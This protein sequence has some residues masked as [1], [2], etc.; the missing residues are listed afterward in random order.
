MNII[1]LTEETR[2]S[3][4]CAATIGFF[5]GVHK[6][7]RHLI[8]RMNAVAAAKRMETTV[9]TFDRH[10]REV[11]GGD[12]H[13]QLLS[14]Y[15][16]KMLLL[17]Q[18]GIDNC[19]IIPFNDTVAQ[20][21]AHDFMLHL[22]K[23]RLSVDTLIIGHDHRFGH[24]RSEDFADYVA[25]GR[26]MGIDVLRGEALV[27]EGVAV[28]S[29]VVRS[30]LLEGETAM[31]EKCLGYQY[32]FKGRVVKGSQTGTAMGFPTANTEP[33][34]PQKLIPAAGVYGVRVR[35]EN[36][37]QNVHAMTNI[38][39]RPTFDG[40]R[41]TI[42]THIFRFSGDLYGQT[43]TIYFGQ[44]LRAERKFPSQ[45]ELTAQLSEDMIAI[46]EM[47]IKESDTPEFL[48]VKTL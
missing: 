32:S 17:A 23:E 29:S 39:T 38:G 34:S 45:E 30:L 33:L 8:E 24:G 44:R 20:T 22:L 14:T 10:P 31:A 42:E 48:G 7:H 12:Y 46:D 47:F 15:D 26:E 40:Q 9:I 21:S 11:L 35:L 25:Y 1:R 16:E 41:Q 4:P 37:M 28:S 13:P 5:D 43:M 3:K 27:I 6:G 2:I 18:T 19:I 36:T